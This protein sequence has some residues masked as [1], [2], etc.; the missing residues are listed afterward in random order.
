MTVRANLSSATFRKN[1]PGLLEAAR[2]VVDRGVPAR[3]VTAGQGQLADEVAALHRASGLGDRFRLLGYRDDTTRLIA[4]ADLF[5]LSS[6]HEG[7]PVTVMEALTLGVP[8]V[9]TAVGGLP[10]A[11]ATEINGILV[12]PRDASA[13][14]DAIQRAVEPATHA[15]LVEAAAGTGDRFSNAPAVARIEA[16]YASLRPRA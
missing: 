4:A 9:A 2:L 11:V 3:F 16:T 6:H 7:L 14:A 1:Y 5:V 15:R 8:V 12:S 10:E 13:L